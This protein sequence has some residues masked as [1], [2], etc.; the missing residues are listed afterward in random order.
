MS[1]VLTRRAT[2]AFD[3]QRILSDGVERARSRLEY[4]ALATAFC[5]PQFTVADLRNVYEIVW[6]ETLDPRNFH[7]K[8]TGV[9]DFLVPT[10]G[11]TTKHG[12]RPAALYRRGTAD[13][14]HPPI[15][16]STGG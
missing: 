9:A 14:L 1:Q 5:P 11:H 7:R 4:S 3:H 13:V 12:G 8:V 6:G 15:L 10:G 2:L 16:R